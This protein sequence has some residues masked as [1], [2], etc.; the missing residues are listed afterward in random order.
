MPDEPIV[1]KR[2][3][4]RRFYARHTSKYVSL[5][6]IE[7]MIREG[8]TVEIRDSQSG[9]DLTRNVLAQII[10]ERQPEKMSLFP[11][12]MLHSIVRSNELMTGFLRDYFSH[13]L[14]Y[15]EY[16]QKHGAA[17]ATMAKPMHWVK[18]WLDGMKHSGAETSPAV[19]APQPDTPLPADPLTQRVEQLEQRIRELEG[20]GENSPTGDGG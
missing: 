19:D 12:D 3:P 7:E 18:A 15:L 2:Y 10:L 5:Q 4:N 6:E 16:L 1:I 13:S 14:V 17:A 9:E 11:T 8:D 20:A